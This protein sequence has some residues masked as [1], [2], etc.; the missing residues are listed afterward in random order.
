MTRSA[1]IYA[2]QTWLSNQRLNPA[3]TNNDLSALL[4]WA[5]FACAALILVNVQSTDSDDEL[6][7]NTTSQSVAENVFHSNVVEVLPLFNPAPQAESATDKW[8]TD[9]WLSDD[10]VLLTAPPSNL[11]V[12]LIGTLYTGDETSIAVIEH[13]GRQQSVRT[14]D[15]IHMLPAQLVR[16]AQDR[17]VI[18]NNKQYATVHFQPQGR[19]ENKEK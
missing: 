11:P 5:G 4:P 12:R 1:I 9:N 19:Q 8:R 14:G 17:I 6:T 10:P 15:R 7:L 13:A 3:F 2:A 18:E 16:V